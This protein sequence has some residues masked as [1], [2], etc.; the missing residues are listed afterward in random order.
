MHAME[1]HAK[2]HCMQKG[3]LLPPPL[4]SAQPTALL[5]PAERNVGRSRIMSQPRCPRSRRCAEAGPHRREGVFSRSGRGRGSGA[6]GRRDFGAGGALVAAGSRSRG[7]AGRQAGG[8]FSRRGRGRGSGA[9]GRF[10]FGAGGALGAAGSRTH[11]RAGR[12]A[13]AATLFTMGRTFY[14][15]LWGGGLLAHALGG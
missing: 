15:A 6:S 2:E 9:N 11:A 4:G 13:D 14:G 12:Q 7:R 1:K 10:D 3:G 5:C 8:G